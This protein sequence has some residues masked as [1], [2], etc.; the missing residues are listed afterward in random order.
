VER[1][2]ALGCGGAPIL[3]WTMAIRA[4]SLIEALNALNVDVKGNAGSSV[5]SE[6][7]SAAETQ[8]PFIE[9]RGDALPHP[10]F[11][12][13]GCRSDSSSMKGHW[14]NKWDAVPMEQR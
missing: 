14:V 4:A 2:C 7:A 13:R 10:Y 9:V 8:C 6:V 3:R 12:F 11:T 5:G 1:L